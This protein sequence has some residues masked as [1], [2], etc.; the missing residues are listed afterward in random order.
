MLIYLK[1]VLQL[2]RLLSTMN[3]NMKTQKYYCL[4]LLHF[5]FRYLFL[6]LF[7][8]GISSCSKEEVEEIPC[9]ECVGP[10]G[11]TIEITDPQSPMYGVK[12]IIPPGSLQKEGKLWIQD[13]EYIYFP[14]GIK[15]YHEKSG[16]SF[17]T[18]NLPDS[19]PVEIRIP[20]HQVNLEPYEVISIFYSDEFFDKW[21]LV[22]PEEITDEYISIKTNFHPDW[23]WGFIDLYEIDYEYLEPIMHRIH[24]EAQ[25]REIEKYIEDYLNDLSK[26]KPDFSCIT[27]DVMN[28][29]F[30]ITSEEYKE[31]VLKFQLIKGAICGNCDA[32][33]AAYYDELFRYVILNLRIKFTEIFT[34]GVGGK[35]YIKLFVKVMAGVKIYFIQQEINNL[36]CDHKCFFE[37]WDDEFRK[38]LSIYLFTLSMHELIEYAIDE[39]IIDCP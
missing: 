9:P 16:F 19:F 25:W 39:G 8:I 21:H 6:F 5:N 35:W 38:D 11:G 7:I 32:T 4:S 30:A 2:F 31:K 37:H 36:Q 10:G 15:P 29:A 14:E 3:R 18:Y 17:S 34:D 20:F 28:Q 23:S 26:D 33:Q 22:L 13:H 12:V 1:V 27:L 24:G